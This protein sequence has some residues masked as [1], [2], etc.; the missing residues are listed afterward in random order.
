MKTVLRILGMFT[1]V[2]CLIGI[3]ASA[4]EGYHENITALW[5]YCSTAVVGYILYLS[6]SGMSRLEKDQQ[7]CDAFIRIEREVLIERMRQWDRELEVNEMTELIEFH[8]SPLESV[9]NN[10]N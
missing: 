1:V 10:V 6:T 3:V 2:V 4:L 7:I 5:G 8:G 9:I